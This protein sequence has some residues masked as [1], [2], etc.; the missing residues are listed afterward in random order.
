MQD[1]C[2][3][4][5]A[6]LLSSSTQVPTQMQDCDPALGA[7]KARWLG[8]VDTSAAGLSEA[9]RPMIALSKVI[10]LEHHN[11]SERKSRSCLLC[12]RSGGSPRAAPDFL[13][14]LADYDY[15]KMSRVL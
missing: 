2:F 4:V 3:A 10:C 1:L 6:E 15:A 14:V 9:I 7:A 12:A 8:T 13:I 11:G 5:Q